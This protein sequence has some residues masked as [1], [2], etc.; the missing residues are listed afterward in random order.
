M[1]QTQ[2]HGEQVAVLARRLIDVAAKQPHGVSLQALLN[3]YAAVALKHPCCRRE[4]VRALAHIASFIEAHTAAAPAD[5][6]HIH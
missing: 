1:S 2:E 3:V 6:A 4:S 5:A